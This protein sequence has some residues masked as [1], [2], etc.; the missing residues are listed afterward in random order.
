APGLA[1][2]IDEVPAARL[3][4]DAGMVT[5][6]NGEALKERRH[7]AHNGVLMVSVVLDGNSRI[8]S[9]PQVRSLG[10]PGD[11]DYP[12]EDALDDLAE[13]AETA[14]KKLSG[15]ERDDDHAVE[16]TLSRVVKKAAFRIWERRPVVETTV[17]RV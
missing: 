4:V 2:I 5:P 3:Y 10:L 14:L 1:E 15:D 7:A 8:A 12:L 11:A 9:G 17:L 13:E 16:T 6:E